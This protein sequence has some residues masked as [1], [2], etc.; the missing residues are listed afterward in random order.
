MTIYKVHAPSTTSLSDDEDD[1]LIKSFTS[2]LQAAPAQ[3][4]RS[5]S[6]RTA[7]VA[8]SKHS[9]MAHLPPEVLIHILKH[10]HSPRDLHSALR[11]SRTWCEC[12]A[13]LLWQKPAFPVFSILDKMARLLA[14]DGQTFAYAH[15]IRRLN[16]LNLGCDLEDH[17]FAAFHN[18]DRL[19]RL[20]LIN[21]DRLSGEV[22]AQ[23]LPCFPNL[24]AV[25]LNGVSSTTD[26]AIVGLAQAARRL[27]GINLAG[28]SAVTDV[29]VMALAQNCAYLRRVKLSGLEALTDKPVSALALSCPLLLEIDLNN[30]QGVTDLALRD[31]WEHAYNMRE[32]KLS[33]CTSLTNAAFPAPLRTPNSRTDLPNPFTNNGST[34]NVGNDLPPLHINRI[35]EQLRIL[36][37]TACSLITD[38]AIEGIISHAPKIRVLVLSKCTALTDKSVE[39][40]CKLGRYLHDLHLGHVVNITD[41]SVRTLARSCIR[42]RYVDFANCH[43]LT[44]LSVFELSSLPKL[45]RIGLVRVNNITDEA[46]YALA[47]RHA[48][49]ERVHLSYCDQISI[50]AIHFLL[51]KLHKLTHLSLTGVPA[52]RQWDLQQF[53]REP[54]KD[55]NTT[56]QQVFCVYSG[57]G[58][59][60]LRAYLTE[61]YDRINEMNG[62]D[63]T[64]YEDDFD[65]Y[66]EEDTPEPEASTEAEVIEDYTRRS[67]FFNGLVPSQVGPS[68]R[69][70]EAPGGPLALQR[71][72]LRTAV[73]SHT[74]SRYYSDSPSAATVVAPTN[75]VNSNPPVLTT[76]P[77]AGPSSS[78]RSRPTIQA[79][80]SMADILPIVEG[81][82]SP[83]GSETASVRS[84]QSNGAAFFR[85]YQDGAATAN[86]NGALTPDLIFAE[87]GHGRGASTTPQAQHHQPRYL[88]QP[89]TMNAP[90]A[91]QANPSTPSSS[92]RTPTATAPQALN[93]EGTP[94]QEPTNSR[95]VYWPYRETPTPTE[96]A[97]DTQRN[98]RPLRNSLPSDSYGYIMRRGHHQQEDGGGQNGGGGRQH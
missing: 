56:Q 5:S 26:A 93:S 60:Q 86:P 23:T 95:M 52:F 48:T 30:C 55:F 89:A 50:G 66:Q 18:C 75:R 62:T 10:L 22:L 13:E 61:V 4:S 57:K 8:S 58:V 63:D 9:P 54:P 42:L 31:I 46:I 73:P 81:S 84:S 98:R 90:V 47:D 7:L 65:G 85:S 33:H 78:R 77:V 28:C 44:D 43:N 12:S 16:F 88:R 27:Q 67:N 29:G 11:V 17:T 21:C 71:E 69:T 3:W 76:T 6:S 64:E 96:A 39:I 45:H 72:R 97:D 51:Q 83:P 91:H 59:A 15:F 74:S 92:M 87:I 1:G 36:D 49:L 25:D 41:R 82:N 80:R 32:I 24:V 37:L 34:P 53:C 19:E 20:T 14:S 2:Q 40:I 94:T 35:F 38:E 68:S 79:S 70:Q